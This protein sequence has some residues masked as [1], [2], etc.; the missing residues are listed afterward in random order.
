V[1]AEIYSWS[2]LIGLPISAGLYV[3]APEIVVLLFGSEFSASVKPLRILSWLV[4]MTCIVST[5]IAF[6]SARDKQH[7][8]MRYQIT[9][10]IISFV[11][12]II[13]ISYLGILGAAISAIVAE[14]ALVFALIRTTAK[15]TGF[16]IKLSTLTACVAGV[17]TFFLL[18]VVLDE[19]VLYWFV[20]VCMVLYVTVL[21]LFPSVRK[22]ELN[23][24]WQWFRA[25]PEE[26]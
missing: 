5:L 10:A 12:N 26:P 2:L 9:A 18:R 19:I 25:R 1:L 13:L 16:P 6:L 7:L 8:V 17:S 3:T 20:P 23:M 11:T 4:L 22:N 24:L 14:G 15:S 21:C